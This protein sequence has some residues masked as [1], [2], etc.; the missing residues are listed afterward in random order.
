MR[1]TAAA[2]ILLLGWAG[3]AQATVHCATR[4][5]DPYRRQVVPVPGGAWPGPSQ[6]ADAM[7]P[8][9]DPKVGDSWLWYTWRLA[10]PPTAVQKM[11]TVRG[12]GT[13][14]YVVVEDTQWQTRV[15]QDDV[16]A[17]V[18]AWDNASIGTHP[19]EGIYELDTTHFGPAPDELDN[20]PKIYVLLYDFD[21]SAD[22]FFWVFDEYPDGSQP[23]A[24]NECEVLYINCSDSDPGGSYLISVMAHEF[25]HMIHWNVDSDEDA[26][27]DEGMAELGMW[28]YGD[29]DPITQFPTVPDNDLTNWTGA[30]SD[31]VK[32]YLW[33]LYYYEQFG[34]Q[35]AVW[36]LV[37]EQAN[38]VQGYENVFDALGSPLNFNDVFANWTCAN[39]LDNTTLDQGQYGYVGET[40]PTFASITKSTYPVPLTSGSV[41]RYAADYVKFIN[42]SPLRLRFDGADA[43]VWK[44]RVLFL[45]GGVAQ[46]VADIP[47]DAVDFGTIDLVDFGE[48]HDTA[49]LV[50]AKTSPTGATS[51]QYATEAVPAAVDGGPLLAFRLASAIPNPMRDGGTIGFALPRAQ[52]VELSIFD[53]SGRLVRNL[54]HAPFT[55]GVHEIAWDG[56]DEEGR[57]VAGGVYFVRLRGEDGDA[58]RRWV[59]VN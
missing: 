22:G 9:A 20:D 50:I 47:L 46:R 56:T 17:I 15:F 41:Q 21:I 3:L 45:N 33:S 28:L 55:A 19:T 54:S 51:Y 6:K 43:G 48:T 2:L 39:F 13:T 24:S 58:V 59:R 40:L 7:S 12:E 37:H 4:D 29:P 5:L 34:G 1:R 36:A 49:V 44:P 38:S 26:W 57:P 23:Y 10:G 16:D 11:C 53:S 32:T 52:G 31:Y 35:P 18:N 30:F 8:P 42:G 14:V 27:V 25:E